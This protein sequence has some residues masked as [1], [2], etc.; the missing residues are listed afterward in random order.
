MGKGS[1][2]LVHRCI[3]LSARYRPCGHRKSLTFLQFDAFCCTFIYVC[4]RR[5]FCAKRL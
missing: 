1:D 5:G 3:G 2:Y 4:E